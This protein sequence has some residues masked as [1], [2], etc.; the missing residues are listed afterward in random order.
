[1][2]R[3]LVEVALD[4][5]KPN[6]FQP[7]KFFSDGELNELAQSI[8]VN[9]LLQPP[10]IATLGAFYEIIAGERR[11]QACRRL[12]LKEIQA[13]L[14]E[15]SDQERLEAA[16]IENLQRVDLNPMEVAFSLKRMA[17]DLKMDQET[18]AVRIGKKRSTVS[19]YMRLLQLPERIQKEISG[20][21]VSMAHA[22]LLLS[23]DEVELRE[24]LF[25]TILKNGSTIKE[26]LSFIRKWRKPKAIDV[27]VQDV[28]A[29]LARLLGTKV[30]IHH[31]GEG[32][33]V[34]VSYF[35]LDDLE[36]LLMLL[37]VEQ[38]CG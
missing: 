38:E 26:S 4:S 21:S 16:L 13:I 19:N 23:C 15:M 32:G 24:E 14:V 37:G 11:V 31:K 6:R 33:E 36:R 25:Q 29:R 2:K 5:L 34:S 22:K 28:E 9:G 17:D 30:A 20:G 3:R 35:S 18:I 7:R 8:D 12:G 10:I 27:H 1:M